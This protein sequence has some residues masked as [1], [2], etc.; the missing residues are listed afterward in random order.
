MTMGA[1]GT[2]AQNDTLVVNT[3]EIL[4]GEIKGFDFGVI[5]IETDYSDSDFKV[6]W[7]KVTSIKT[8]QTFVVITTNGDRYFGQ[9]IS[10][11]QDPSN[12]AIIDID[13]A[14]TVVKIGD[15]VFFKEIEDTFWSRSDLLLSAGYTTTKANNL[16]QFTGKVEVGY[17]SERFKS[18]LSVRAIRSVQSVED[19]SAEVSRTEGGIGILFF[20]VRDW[21]AVVRSDLLQSSELS[22]NIRAITKGG[23]GYYIIKTTRMNLGLAGGGAWNYEDYDDPSTSG[24]NSAEAFIA[25]EY[26]IFNLGELD[27]LTKV[28]GYPSLTESGRFRTDI[29]FSLSHEFPR[30]LFIEFGFGF[31]YDNQ[32]AEGASPSDYVLETTIGWEL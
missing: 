25:A 2:F 1:S 17:L 19:A 27:L 14:R 8:A 24:R 32:P 23:V 28:I 9:L 11:R 12:V 21:F 13:G 7:D 30:D 18:D 3:G 5:T 4:V 31:N 29:S 10:G 6:E 15:I 16:H 22:L 26:N 20:L